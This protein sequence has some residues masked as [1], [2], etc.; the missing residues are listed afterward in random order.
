MRRRFDR[1]NLRYEVRGIRPGGL[2]RNVRELIDPIAAARRA[3]PGRPSVIVYCPTRKLA[4]QNAASLASAGYSA[5]AYHAGLP[6]AKRDAAQRR[7]CSGETMAIV[8]TCAFGSVRA[9]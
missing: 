6:R 8:A 1:P 9:R 4:E 3:G 7:W 5:L 2:L